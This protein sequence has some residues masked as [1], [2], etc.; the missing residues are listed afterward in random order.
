MARRDKTA[1]SERDNSSSFTVLPSDPTSGVKMQ[2]T[3]ILI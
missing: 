2:V 1:A 3:I